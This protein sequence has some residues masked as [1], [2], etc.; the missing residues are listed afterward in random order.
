MTTTDLKTN[1][2]V[3]EKLEWT[4]GEMMIYSKDAGTQIIQHQDS[5]T[6]YCS[7]SSNSS[8]EPLGSY[9]SST[10]GNKLLAG[11]SNEIDRG[12][13]QDKDQHA[14][15]SPECNLGSIEIVNPTT[16][17][18]KALTL[19]PVNGTLWIPRYKILHTTEN[20]MKTKGITFLLYNCTTG[21]KPIIIL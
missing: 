2:L 16:P 3:K 1:N 10:A 4:F 5:M 6:D 21:I 14:S 20:H 18:L 9:C 7:L 11:H 13:D 17:Q 8:L 15:T 12:Q 19:L